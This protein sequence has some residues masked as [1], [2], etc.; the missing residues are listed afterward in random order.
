[1]ME[2]PLYYLL[3]SLQ[4][5]HT[6]VSVLLQYL[7]IWHKKTDVHQ[8]VEKMYTAEQTPAFVPGRVLHIK[9]TEGRAH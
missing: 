2:R 1:M 6:D 8:F 9:D 4:L 7:K 5:I 3:V